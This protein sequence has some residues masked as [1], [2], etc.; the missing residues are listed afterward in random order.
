MTMDSHITHTY[1]ILQKAAA[2]AAQILSAI[3][4]ILVSFWADNSD[5]N[6]KY[7]QPHAHEDCTWHA[8]LMVVSMGFCLVQALLAYRVL[9]FDHTAQKY[10]HGTINIAGLICALIGVAKIVNFHNSDQ[11]LSNL[12]SLHSWLG[13][14]TL[15]LY[16]QNYV[17]GFLHFILPLFSL[18]LKKLY[19]PSHKILGFMTLVVAVVTMETGIIQKDGTL[20]CDYTVTSIDTN[21]ASHY[22]NIPAGCRL[23]SGL[24]IILVVILLL[25]CFAIQELPHNELKKN[26]IRTSIQT[27]VIP[28]TGA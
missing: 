1:S 18:E 11:S 5:T 20:G 17:L 22:L 16:I 14:V 12:T 2:Y 23:S 9:P 26:V 13:L 4:I 7:K 15:I 8:I 19:L 25:V 24:G 6:Q 21:P 10:I 3:C 28:K 27:Q